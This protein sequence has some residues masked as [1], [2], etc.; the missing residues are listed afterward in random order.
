MKIAI[1]HCRR[2]S[3]VCTGAGCFRAYNNCEKSF[4]QYA[5]DQPLLAAFLDCG[6][7]GID[8]AED[9]GM[10]E[11]MEAL[12]HIGVEKI[13]LGIC[14]NEKC[15]SLSNIIEMLDRYGIAYEFGT[16]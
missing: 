9:P 8:R 6:G 12:Q 15:P 13:H 14:I 1:L 7:Y 2:S 16:H 4:A 11:K 5:G 10:I 3:D